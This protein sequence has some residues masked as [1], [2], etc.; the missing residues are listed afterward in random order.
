MTSNP[1]HILWG[2]I[3]DH[4]VLDVTNQV[5]GLT[6]RV[7]SSS[8]QSVHTLECRNLSELRF[9]NS[10]PG[11]W[12]YSE[13]TQINSNVNSAGATQLEIILWSEDAGLV[14][15]ADSVILDGQEIGR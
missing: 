13:V 14:A 15:V 9:F 11:P 10:I 2:A 4:V 12:K 6:M 8:G 3:L 1:L 7:D 5:L